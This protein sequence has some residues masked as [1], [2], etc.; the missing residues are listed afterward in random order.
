[1]LQMLMI[2]LE[3]EMRTGEKGTHSTAFFGKDATAAANLQKLV[4]M[5]ERL[6]PAPKAPRTRKKTAATEESTLS[7]EEIALLAEW[8]QVE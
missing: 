6:S 4:Q 7:R 8:M 3:E 5:L 2:T 1:M